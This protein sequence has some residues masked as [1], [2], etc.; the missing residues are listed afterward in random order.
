[1]KL[2]R[3]VPWA[4]SAELDTVCTWIYADE[5]D[6]D[7][8]TAAVNRLSAW[9]AIT[10]LPHALEATLSLLSS[11]RLDHE[12]RS[13]QQPRR[14]SDVP[15]LKYTIALSVRQ[16]YATAIVRLVNGLVDPLQ[17][18]AFARSIAAIA[19]Q[20]GFP[21]WLVELRHAATHEELPSLELLRAGAKEALA[22]LLHNYF[23]PTLSASS[24]NEQS[25][26]VIHLSSPSPIFKQYKYLL[27]AITRDASLRTQYKP[28]LTKV[29]RDVE[30]WVGEAK[31]AASAE[32]FS[33]L[34]AGEQGEV[35]DE[36]E[37]WALERLCEA[38]LER[39][40][41]VPVS[42]K[43]RLVQNSKTLPVIPSSLVA[44]WS[45]LL[46]ALRSTHSSFLSVLVSSI[47]K[48]LL[49]RAPALNN[50]SL[51]KTDLSYELCLAAWAAWCVNQSDAASIE[52]PLRE[53]ATSLRREDV[54]VG[55]VTALCARECDKNTGDRQGAR[56]LID[57]LV[58]EH[59][60]LKDVADSLSL[61]SKSGLKPGQKWLDKDV[62]VMEE[63]LQS[64]IS[65]VSSVSPLDDESDQIIVLDEGLSTPQDDLPKGWTRVPSRLWKACP[66]GVFNHC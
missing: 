10:P 47:T 59:P 4:T 33:G 54:V 52:P 66:I 11:V 63:R 61:A 40:G 53:G 43:K 14:H 23:L 25:S 46:S 35:D 31:V 37:R 28:D 60:Y 12:F 36:N 58:H 2:P 17:L 7:A 20:I 48:S 18:G 41:L 39:G 6:A 50:D 51:Q 65:S 15:N 3:R 42:G 13:A 44:I 5:N 49:F 56:A 32:T 34:G 21:Q 45:P 24:N 16:A 62:L 38:L 19:A 64:L 30:R 27:K 26:P 9:R 1:M 55:L 57:L 8:K 22:W 29:L